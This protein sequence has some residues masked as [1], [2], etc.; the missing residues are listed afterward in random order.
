MDAI[1]SQSWTQVE[2]FPEW[3][4]SNN[5][6][7]LHNWTMRIMTARSNQQGIKMVN[8]QKEKK[9]FT[10]SVALL[11]AKAYL[12]PPRNDNYN[13]VI[14]LNGDREDCRFE[15]LM[16]RPRWYA[17]KYHQMFDDLP[18][19]L[20]VHIPRTG[21]HFTSL[22]EACTTYGL[23]EKNTYLD[24]INEQPCFHYGWMIEKVDK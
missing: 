11:V 18:Y 17:V 16:W 12:K 8:L 5:G 21:E 19:R 22:R 15:N 6:D 23:I 13:S 14:H 20:G 2:G 7:V 1:S 3:L 4:V 24:V 9:I 10:R